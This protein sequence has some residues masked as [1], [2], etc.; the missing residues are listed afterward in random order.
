MNSENEVSWTEGLK[1]P[2]KCATRGGRWVRIEE[3]RGGGW[4]LL[5]DEGAGDV[6]WWHL[7]EENGTLTPLD[8]LDDARLPELRRTVTE[9]LR[10]SDK[11]EL[12]AWRVG[13][14]AIFR[15]D[16]DGGPRMA[17]VYRKDRDV[18]RRWELLA[19]TDS[20]EWSVPRVLDWKPKRKRL[21]IEF[22]AGTSLNA[23]WL[24]GSADPEDGARVARLLAWLQETPMPADFPAHPISEEIR[25][26][27]ERVPVF[28]RTLE[29]PSPRA[30][31]LFERVRAELEALPEVEP[32]LCH[33]DF[34]DKQVLID[35]DRGTLIDLDLAA[36]GHPALDVGNILAHL[37]LRQLKG[38]DL[39]WA[40]VARPIAERAKLDRGI[41]DSLRAWTASTLM[42]L[43]LIYARR[44]RKPGLIDALLDSTEA[45]LDGTGEWEG[46][47]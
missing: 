34:H 41:E 4:I 6:D 35:G 21:E 45:A 26:L 30:T 17:K 1:E 39:N 15:F 20:D 38:A 22:C 25:V 28:Y 10:R 9:A 13:S 19:N 29:N 18:L 7:P 16:G 47:L 5:S 12:L 33:R 32:V 8:P 11:I 14:R 40:V 31:P 42:R 46:I 43:A 2:L 24:G 23:R 37:R 36:A 3:H 27:S 44:Y